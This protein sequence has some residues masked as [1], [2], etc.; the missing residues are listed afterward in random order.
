MHGYEWTAT[1]TPASGDIAKVVMQRNT[2]S[3]T[4]LVQATV[5]SIYNGTTALGGVFSM[6]YQ[7]TTSPKYPYEISAR[8]LEIELSAFLGESMKI[9]VEYLNTG[10]QWLVTFPAACGNVPQLSIN[11]TELTGSN[12]TASVDTVQNG[13]ECVSGNFTLVWN[14]LSTSPISFN[15]SEV[16]LGREITKM[17]TGHLEGLVLVN[18]VA[19]YHDVYEWRITFPV[20]AGNVAQLRALSG[21]RG[22]NVSITASTMQNGTY[23]PLDGVFY[24]EFGREITWNLSYNATATEVQDALRNLSSINQ[25]LV[26]TSSIYDSEGYSGLLWNITFSASG[27][28]AQDG[29]VDIIRVRPFLQGKNCCS[30]HCACRHYNLC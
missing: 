2:L 30:L 23:T 22:S 25:N 29:E 11:Y 7:A 1:F 19:H 14:S 9:S 21:L 24:L 28:P 5:N 15:A 16:L 6:Q 26:V 12:F 13:T 4:S 8:D 20:S 10:K 17:M 3:S 27:V 18:R